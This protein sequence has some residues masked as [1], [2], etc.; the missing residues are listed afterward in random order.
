MRLLRT[1]QVCSCLSH[2]LLSPPHVRETALG[3][4]EEFQGGGQ[5]FGLCF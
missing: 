3:L 1:A 2:L 5:E 4:H